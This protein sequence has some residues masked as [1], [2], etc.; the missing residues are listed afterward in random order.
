MNSVNHVPLRKPKT[1][2]HTNRDPLVAA[3]DELNA[4][5]KQAEEQLAAMRVSVW[6]EVELPVIRGGGAGSSDFHEWDERDS[7]C[8]G[9]PDKEWRLCISTTRTYNIDNREDE[10][11]IRPVAECSM[12]DRIKLV[13]HFPALKAKMVEARQKLIPVVADAIAA[14]KNA[15][16]M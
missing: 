8:W 1:P 13:Q 12:E 2:P 6:V 7:L 3:Y 16:A 4:L 15:L 11:G 10:W 5:W 9:K 14:L